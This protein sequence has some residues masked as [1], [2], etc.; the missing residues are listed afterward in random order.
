MNQLL[1]H[2]SIWPSILYVLCHPHSQAPRHM[3]IV[4]T[5]LGMGHMF[6][7]LKQ[8]IYMPVPYLNHTLLCL[9]HSQ[10]SPVFFFGL[11]SM[12]AEEWPFFQLHGL[13]W[14]Q[15][16]EQNTGEAWEQD[17]VLFCDCLPQCRLGKRVT[18]YV[19]SMSSSFPGSTSHDDCTYKPGNRIHC[20]PQCR[21]GKRVT[22]Y[23]TRLSCCTHS[24]NQSTVDETNSSCF[25]RMFL[26][27]PFTVCIYVFIHTHTHT[28]THTHKLPLL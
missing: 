24:N 2:L 9:P 19:C 8:V 17:Y 25:I 14:V 5:S 11:C 16:E 15:T 20:L 27:C 1:L 12:E 6:C 26:V 18:A 3:M 21:L 28:H 4:L 7:M 23:S 10:A 13:Y 22:A